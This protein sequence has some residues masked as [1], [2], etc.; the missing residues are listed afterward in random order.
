MRSRCGG[1][2]DLLRADAD[3]VLAGVHCRLWRGR[4]AAGPPGRRARQGRHGH[5]PGRAPRPRSCPT[6]PP[7]WSAEPMLSWRASGRTCRWPTAATTSTASSRRPSSASSIAWWPA[8]RGGIACP[9]LHAANTAGAIAFPAAPTTWSV[10][11]SASTA[12]CPAVRAGRL[13]RAS[14]G[15]ASG[16]RHGAEGPGGRG[17]HARC[18]GAPLV[19]PAPPVARRAAGGHRPDRLR[20]RRAPRPLRRRL[21]GPDRR[22]CA[23]RWPGW[24]P[25]TR[26]SSTAGPTT[27]CIPATRSSCSG[28]RGTRRSRRTTGRYCW[29]RSVTR[30]SAASGRGCRAFWSTVLTRP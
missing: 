9:L 22:E 18:G 24:S 5:A 15:R 10:A 6:L 21:R 3:G 8:G 16:P 25:W 29:A 19:R 13:R 7:R 20:R 14:A 17:A 26:S 11:G 1:H 28:G 2:G 23:G 30:W 12:T 27:R 4:A